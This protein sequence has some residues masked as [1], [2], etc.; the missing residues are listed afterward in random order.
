MNGRGSIIA[1][2]LTAFLIASAV[3]T[4]VGPYRVYAD[5]SPLTTMNLWSPYNPNGF[6]GT[7]GSTITFSANAACINGLARLEWDFNGD[8]TVDATTPVTGTNV[9]NVMVSH[10]YGMDGYYN[11]AVRSVD[12]NNLVSSWATYDKTGAILLDIG[13]N[14]PVVTMDAWSPASGDTLTTFTFTAHAT[15]EVGL[16]ALHWD[17]EGDG[18]VDA[19]TSISGNSGTGSIT[20]RYT[21]P[22]T[23]TPQ[24]YAE[25]L[26][27]FVSD[28]DQYDISG[29]VV[30][31]DVTPGPTAAIMK[32]W[33]PYSA[34]G[35]SGTTQTSFTFSADASA[36]AGISR[37]EWDFNG[38]G[39]VDATTP[40]AGAPIIVAGITTSH[41][42]GI[43]GTYDPAVRVVDKNNAASPWDFY[44]VSGTPMHLVVAPSILATMNA[45]SPYSATQYD[46]NP[47]TV[48]TFSAD[49]SAPAGISRLEW[50]FNGDGTVDATTPVAGAPKTLTG[51]TTTH[52]Y[53]IT[54]TFTPQ[55]RAISINNE[56]SSWSQYQSSGQT[57]QLDIG[58]PIGAATL[59]FSPHTSVLGQPD[60]TTSTLFTFT[61]TS[62]LTPVRFDWDFN[63]DEVI[64]ASTTTPSATFI[65]NVGGTYYPSMTVWDIYGGHTQAVPLNNIGTQIPLY[66][67]GS[68]TATMGAWSPYSPTGADGFPNTV[69]TFSADASAPAGISRLEW[70]FNGDGTVDSITIANGAPIS[71]TGITTTYTF[72]VTGT[73]TPKVRSVD[74][75]GFASFWDSYDQ[76][77]KVI[78]LDI[79][80]IPVPNKAPIS[81]AGPNQSVNVAQLVILDGSGS[82]DPDIGDSITQYK[83][84]QTSGPVQLT[85]NLVN[86]VKP[87]FIPT[88]AGTYAFD[89][90]VIDNHGLAS[91]SSRVTITVNNSQGNLYCD[92][93]TIDQLI[94]GGHYNVIDLR[95][96]DKK[97]VQGTERDD[98]IIANNKGDVIHGRGGNDCII[99]GTG[100]D[101]LYGDDGSKYGYDQIY[102]LGGNDEIHGGNGNDYINGGDGNDSGFTGGGN[103]TF[104]S[105]EVIKQEDKK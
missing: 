74:A 51:S 80:P 17:F 3:I 90:V 52:A 92:G 103:D 82:Y 38:D 37:L 39:T 97:E 26:Q 58:L 69:F 14:P 18:I 34:T 48:F 59:S 20:H 99:G 56:I 95:K 10:I 63:G 104:V 44:D 11:P 85:L 50:D 91:S 23:F 94:S 62:S 61:A 42:Y 21:T 15:S 78:T 9:N 29:L 55:V 40:V 89:L 88:L 76:N 36:P 43:A 87:N 27:H 75:N 7:P 53:G 100:E 65:Y 28:W 83:W 105:C 8:G 96:S 33:S 16:F 31:L 64:D 49:A 30:T 54:G 79:A 84:T 1:S 19:T 101:H 47:L 45:W 77:G 71:A 32:Q 60:G 86:P 57:I 93:K 68:P 102:G 13:W 4:S 72:G 22:G 66:V 5:S 35:P 6:D 24:V 46:G 25:D 81:N 2:F 73:F 12:I 41:I 67:V 70:D 98:L